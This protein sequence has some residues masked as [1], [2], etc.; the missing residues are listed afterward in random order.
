MPGALQLDRTPTTGYWKKERVHFLS[1]Y[2][3][4]LIKIQHMGM[5][6]FRGRLSGPRE[7][8]AYLIVGSHADS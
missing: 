2:S 5:G 6:R 3:A 1:E 4:D 8:L 7:R